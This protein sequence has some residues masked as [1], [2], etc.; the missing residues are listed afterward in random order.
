MEVVC[1]TICEEQ[2]RIGITACYFLHVFISVRVRARVSTVSTETS[3][4]CIHHRQL[5]ILGNMRLLKLA[6]H[7][8][9]GPKAVCTGLA[10]EES[11]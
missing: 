5:E 10:I 6:L 2:S 9:K 1:E 7:W 4:S 8:D 11:F 3:A